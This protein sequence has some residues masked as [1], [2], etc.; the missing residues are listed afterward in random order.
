[1]NKKNEKEIKWIEV[2]GASTH[3]LKNIDVSIPR[4]KMSVITGLSG[5]GKSSLAFDTIF[6]EGQRRYTE[7]LSAYARQFLKQMKKPDVRE[8][9]GLSPAISID[10]KNRSNNPR[11]TVATVTE[12]YDY[13]RVLFSRVGTPYCPTCNVPIE[14]VS[15]EDVIAKLDKKIKD[16]NW[17]STTKKVAGVSLNERT[18][19][20]YAPV[21]MGRKG[22]Y[23]QMLYDMLRKGYENVS[24]DGKEYSLRKKIEL[25]KHKKHNIDILI[26]VVYLADYAKN[27]KLFRERFSDGVEAAMSLTDGFVKLV[28]PDKVE[29]LVSSKFLCVKCGFSFPE[30]EPRLFSFNSPYGAC[31]ECNGLGQ[32][33]IYEDIPCKKCNGKR[34]RDEA[35]SVYVTNK[36]ERYNI[37]D[38][39]SMSIEHSDKL[40]S[41]LSFGKQ[42]E[43]VSQPLINEIHSRV[44]FMLNVGL[45]YL[46]LDRKANTLSGG[47][48]QRIRLASQLGSRLVGTL[49]VLDEP[50]IGLHQRDNDRLIKSLIDLR[51]IGNT[52]VIVEHD[53][54]TIFASDYIVDIGPGAGRLGG[55]VVTSGFLDKLLTA[56]TNPSKSITLDYLRGDKEISVPKKRRTKLGDLSIRGGKA[57]NIEDMDIDVPLG[58]LTAITG[59]SGSGKSSFL[60]DILH[61][62]LLTKLER[63]VRIK[64]IDNAKEFK[65][66]EDLSR[67]ILIDQSPIGRTPRSTPITYIGAF[68][69]IR[70][71]FAA[72]EEAR[73][74]GWK[75]GRFSFN[76]KG[77]MCEKC[78]G[79]GSISVEMH[80]LPTVYVTCDQ[81]RGKRYN[82]EV[83]EIKYN[84]KTIHDVLSMTVEEA[85]D[86]FK[87]IP[88]VNDRLQTLKDV[89]L[90]Y[91]K[92][93]QPSTTLSGGEAQR[94]KI[95][96][97]LYRPNTRKTI[98]LLD[99]PTVGLHYED[100]SK[101][102]DV[103]NRLVDRGNTVI[104]IEHNL[105]VIKNCD[106][107]IDIGPEGGIRG[108][109]LVAQG[110]PEQVAKSTGSFTGKYLKG[111]LKKS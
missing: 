22:E 19:R 77:G 102:I 16:E 67:S 70:E 2:K 44:S 8:I 65:G 6:A 28:Y 34:L 88:Q 41:T 57:N 93:G 86:F 32:V 23:Y 56:K 99:E 58:L 97:E 69:F 54:D 45:G 90:S 15:K 3:N 13:L 92:L 52:I 78:A 91:I 103:L 84:G 43:D 61:K 17:L 59:V 10:Q 20:I 82:S 106:H 87:N 98:Y 76:V 101:L 51:D 79:N 107:I 30:I 1:M 68:T 4:D 104:V 25:S 80:F 60:Y 83:L 46:T 81:C 18:I 38:V 74:R 42:L 33:D 14:K 100:V 26:D 66:Y 110:T 89:G 39:I 49:Y 47:E 63:R 40:F 105:D 109:K 37:V 5:S 29:E 72:T 94:V 24:I 53:E 36:G 108:G 31:E 21:V 95:S 9:T 71:L 12:I 96:S 62:N 111:V 73:Y 7:S 75:A 11:S 64:R 85:Y 55:E 50:T 35:L 27:P 48:A